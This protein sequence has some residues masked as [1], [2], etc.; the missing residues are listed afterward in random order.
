VSTPYTI[1]RLTEL[2]DS[3]PRFGF[4][5]VQEARFAKDEL[6]AQ[7]TGVSHHRLKPGRRQPF[8]HR[9]ERAEEV[10]VV[11]AGSG[12]VKL[13]GDIVEIS[14][15]DAIRVAPEVTRAFEAGPEGLEVLAFGPRHDGDGEVIQGWWSD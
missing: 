9:H 8:A 11:I 1:K 6:Q 12:R 13:D 5:E 14:P 7:H 3:A 10:Y 15:L 2:T 4:Q